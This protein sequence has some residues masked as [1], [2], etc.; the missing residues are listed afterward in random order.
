MR[1]LSIDDIK[2]ILKVEVRKSVLYSHQV[3][4]QTNK[5]SDSGILDRLHHISD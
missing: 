1:N 3:N 2:E 5:H 4:E